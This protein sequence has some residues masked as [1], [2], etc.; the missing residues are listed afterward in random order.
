MGKKARKPTTAPGAGARDV[1]FELEQNGSVVKG[2]IRFPTGTTIPVI[3][4]P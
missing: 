3:C 4:R 1:L 2:V